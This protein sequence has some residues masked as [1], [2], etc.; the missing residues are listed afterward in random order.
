MT[1]SVGQLQRQTL[2]DSWQARYEGHM[3]AIALGILVVAACS[4]GNQPAGP[5]GGGLLADASSTAPIDAAV[6]EELDASVAG[7]CNGSGQCDDGD[8]CTMDM[9]ESGICMHY[10]DSVCSWPAETGS[11]STNLTE[12]GG[13]IQCFFGYPVAENDLSQNLSGAVWNPV[14]QTLWMVK[15]NDPTLFAVVQEDGEYE[16]AEKDGVPA[17]WEIPG[18]GDVEGITQVDFA[19]TDIVYTMDERNGTIRRIDATDFSNPH[20]TGKWGPLPGLGGAG[21]EGLTFVPDTF[22]TAQGFVD[23]DGDAYTSTK[24]MGGLMF[25]GHQAGGHL[26]VYDLNPLDNQDYVYVGKYSTGGAETAGLE[27]DRSTGVLYIWHDSSIDQLEVV[28]LASTATAGGRVMNT[29]ATYAGPDLS[30]EMAQNME[31]I[32]LGPVDECV[33]GKRRFWMLTD[34]GGCFSLSLYEDFPC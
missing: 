16:Y 22:L 26:Y 19:D 31:G 20:Q 14:S 3:K 1:G 7:F 4:S 15:N 10:S 24:G 9:C 30:L 33:D 12:V 6:S 34:G 2:P 11:E 32:A 5:D 23:R 18:M 28:S 25:V 27:F 17:S 21:A 13:S 8:S 29:I